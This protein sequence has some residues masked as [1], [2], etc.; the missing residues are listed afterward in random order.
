MHDEQKK[1][2]QEKENVKGKTSQG[3]YHGRTRGL[4]EEQR[5]AGD[6]RESDIPPLNRRFF[7]SHFL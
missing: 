3:H 5:K 1:K 4:G 7:F 6:G 2:K